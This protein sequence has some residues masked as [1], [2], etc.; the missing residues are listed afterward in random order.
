MPKVLI[1]TGDAAESLE[2][3]YPYQRLLE[4]GY[5]VDIAAP[6]KKKLQ[7]VVHSEPQAAGRRGDL[8]DHHRPGTAKAGNRATPRPSTLRPSADPMT[9]AG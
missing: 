1:I 4:E 6:S 8:V 5:Q 9:S 2:V 3:M 7:F